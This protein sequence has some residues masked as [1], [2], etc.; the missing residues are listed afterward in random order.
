[1]RRG[2]L[3]FVLAVGLVVSTVG[4]AGAVSAQI[5]PATQ[6]HAHNVAS[7]WTGSWTGRAAFHTEFDYGDGYY[8]PY[9]GSSTSKAYTHG[10]SPCPGDA[11]TYYQLLQVWDN[12]GHG[13]SLYASS[14][15]SAHENAGSPC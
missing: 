4:A 9:D 3:S 10:F 1:M 5:S 2:L 6:S 8:T 13:S 11:T 15:S 7:H 12:I 14:T